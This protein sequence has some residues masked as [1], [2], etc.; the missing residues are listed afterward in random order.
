[1]RTSTNWLGLTCRLMTSG[2]NMEILWILG[3]H[4]G[5]INQLVIVG[6]LL[7]VK[8]LLKSCHSV[9]LTLIHSV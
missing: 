6:E 3:V 9:F 5:P 2:G 7:G 1:M 4:G 8:L